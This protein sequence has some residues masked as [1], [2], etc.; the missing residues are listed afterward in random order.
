MWKEVWIPFTA[1]IYDTQADFLNGLF[2]VQSR[3]SSAKLNQYTKSGFSSAAGWLSS[4]VFKWNILNQRR[5]LTGTFK[6]ETILSP[7]CIIFR[8]GLNV[9]WTL[10]VKSRMSSNYRRLAFVMEFSVQKQKY[11]VRFRFFLWNFVSKHA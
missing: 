11:G 3:F 4:I 9:T 7:I 5:F 2:C 6:V 10:P 8:L 1:E